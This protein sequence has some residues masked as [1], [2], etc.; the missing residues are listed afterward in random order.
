MIK[1]Y[2]KIEPK[3]LLMYSPQIFDKT[4]NLARKHMAAGID[5]ANFNFLTPFPGTKLY[6]YVEENRLLLPNLHVADMNWMRP[7][8]KTKVPGWII[9]LIITKG[10]RFVNKPARIKRIEEMT[11]YYKS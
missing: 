5:S 3:F 11:Y 10:W 2:P 9:K 6:D 4:F 1:I 8:M 7:S